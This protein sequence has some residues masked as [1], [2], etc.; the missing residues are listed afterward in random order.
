[1]QRKTRRII[2]A[3]GVIVLLTAVGA[4]F[5]ASLGGVLDGKNANIGFGSE[6]VTGAPATAVNYQLDSNGQY[7]DAVVVTLTGNFVG[8]TYKG[9]LMISPTSV[10]QTGACTPAT[11]YVA[12]STIVTCD[13]TNSTG[14][15]GTATGGGTAISGVPV[16]TVNGFDL[17]LTGNNDPG[18]TQQVGGG[19]AIP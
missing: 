7:I 4:A 17:S 15:G 18:T 6:T 1:M 3:V 12:P 19:T 8:S 9:S 14:A 13:F 10:E 2:A 16:D 11:P 5:T